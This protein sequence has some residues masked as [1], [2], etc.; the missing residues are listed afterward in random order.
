MLFPSNSSILGLAVGLL[1][2]TE[3]LAG[4]S[5]STDMLSVQV[6]ILTS[7]RSISPLSL[8][9][10]CQFPST[11]YVALTYRGYSS[12]SILVRIEFTGSSHMYQCIRPLSLHII[13]DSFL[14]TN[15]GRVDLWR[16]HLSGSGSPIMDHG[17]KHF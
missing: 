17:A 2:N 9:P 6:S 13:D 11:L 8:L 7:H 4:E 10:L 5:L 16:S 12:T 15:S 1:L 3:S 14:M